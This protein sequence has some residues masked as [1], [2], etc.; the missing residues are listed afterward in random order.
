MVCSLHFPERL[1]HYCSHF[2]DERAYVSVTALAEIV[3][4]VHNIG[5]ESNTS[6]GHLDAL[7]EG[8]DVISTRGSYAIRGGNN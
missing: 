8:F 6:P 1:L 2:V 4:E 7:S 5:S 3:A